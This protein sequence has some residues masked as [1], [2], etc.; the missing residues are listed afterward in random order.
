MKKS[1]DDLSPDEAQQV[2][3]LTKILK[4]YTEIRELLGELNK[5]PVGKE[6]TGDPEPDVTLMSKSP[7]YTYLGPDGRPLPVDRQ[8]EVGR[9]PTQLG[10]WFPVERS[11]AA[12]AK[13]GTYSLFGQ[14]GA[15]IPPK[16]VIDRKN[17]AR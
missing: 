14:G 9:K 4:K 1:L 11:A 17:Q 13:T 2:N 6:G 15:R 12:A 10:S 7:K 8:T 3:I 5:E 16:N